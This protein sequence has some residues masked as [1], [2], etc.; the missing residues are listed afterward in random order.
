[1]AEQK[2]DP[3]EYYLGIELGSTRIKAVLTDGNHAVKATGTHGWENRYE[4][5]YWTYPLES[6]W[7]GMRAAFGELLENYHRR[8]RKR[9][10]GAQCMCISGM[11]HGYLP[12]DRAG[13]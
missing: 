4:D 10:Q 9:L 1:M 8:Y 3:E 5:G 12:F 6:V 2:A 13:K 7:D 11:M